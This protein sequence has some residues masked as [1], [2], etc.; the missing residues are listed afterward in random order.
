MHH[1]HRWSF[2][3]PLDV[4]YIVWIMNIVVSP[5]SLR[6]NTVLVLVKALLM[7][8]DVQS[9]INSVLIWCSSRSSQLIWV[10]SVVRNSVAN[11]CSSSHHVA[12]MC[13]WT[14]VKVDTLNHSPKGL[15]TA[16]HK[17]LRFHSQL[18]TA[19]LELVH[20]LQAG[21]GPLLELPHHLFNP[22]SL[23]NQL[24]PLMIN[25]L[26]LLIVGWRLLVLLLV[27]FLLLF[28]WLLSVLLK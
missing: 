24:L 22:L 12:S 27:M 2:D 11:P 5:E 23:L 26:S 28:H 16:H 3:V 4:H 13:F 10:H 14:S 15:T 6:S 20:L 21:V 25:L 18:I 1:H 7:W 19:L 17:G 9:I 8:G